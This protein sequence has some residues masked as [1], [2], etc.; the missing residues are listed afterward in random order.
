ME[1]SNISTSNKNIPYTN[2]N[3][4]YTLMNMGWKRL[5]LKID[6]RCI[7]G[8]DFNDEKFR[9]ILIEVLNKYKIVY[10]NIKEWSLS[11]NNDI[12]IKI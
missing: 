11:M 9:S 7:K 12:L 2:W 8:F 4:I 6:K 10:E 1:S 5:P 3:G